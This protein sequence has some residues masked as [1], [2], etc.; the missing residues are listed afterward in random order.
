MKGVCELSDLNLLPREPPVPLIK[1][2]ITETKCT[3]I[4]HQFL[5]TTGVPFQELVEA[6]MAEKVDRVGIGASKKVTRNRIAD[7]NNR[8]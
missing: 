8:K 5:F 1:K 3:D 7:E 4:F 2:L 6:A